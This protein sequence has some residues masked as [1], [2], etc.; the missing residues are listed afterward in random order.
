MLSTVLMQTV[1]GADHFFQGQ[2]QVG[3]FCRQP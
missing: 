1:D 2:W 3:H